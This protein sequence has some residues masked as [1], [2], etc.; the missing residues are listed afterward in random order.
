MFIEPLRRV[1]STTA[2]EDLLN[3]CRGVEGV[4]EDKDGRRHLQSL[5]M[6]LGIKAWSDDFS[7]MLEEAKNSLAIPQSKLPASAH[8]MIKVFHHIATLIIIV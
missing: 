3:H 8:T 5:G 1:S 6:G 4:G 7:T 2:V